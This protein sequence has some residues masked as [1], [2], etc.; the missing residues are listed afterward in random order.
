MTDINT[1]EETVPATPVVV[2]PISGV[3]TE[4]KKTFTRRPMPARGGF[5][6]GFGGG[7]P[8]GRP[9][10]KGGFGGARDG[11]ET[12]VLS[13][14]R[15]A[16]VIAGGKRFTFSVCLVLGDKKG[17]VGVGLAKAGGTSEA[18][19]KATRDAK[20]NMVKINTT[21]TMSIFHEARAKYCSGI[22]DL[23]PAPG[24]GL[25]AGSA[26]RVVLALAGIT[27]I[28]AK[29]ISGSKNKINNARA[30]WM[31]LKSLAK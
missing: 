2:A 20:K 3:P 25:I 1:K 7:R 27:D 14:R 28:N 9:G 11:M 4:A 13:I 24:R 15:V 10:G 31:A 22:V 19:E 12:K 21:K 30:T 26:P 5:G 8:G 16:R 17:S 18:I 23:R 6:G 29:I